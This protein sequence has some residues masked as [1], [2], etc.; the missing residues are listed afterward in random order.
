MVDINQL[1]LISH[2][3]DFYATIA[4]FS[5]FERIFWNHWLLAQALL[6]VF[7]P[8]CFATLMSLS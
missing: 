2:R 7:V 4:A 6:D 5:W 8:C 1:T 3:L